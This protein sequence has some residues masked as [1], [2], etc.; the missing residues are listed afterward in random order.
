MLS[1]LKET[2]V[3]LSDLDRLTVNCQHCKTQVTVSL[4]T[5]SD[6]YKKHGVVL[7]NVCPGCQK[8]YDVTLVGALE[9]LQRAFDNLSPLAQYLEFRI[10]SERD[11]S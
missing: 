5:P 8:N 7:A 1:M 9:S 6:L 10:A 3:Y 11:V 4:K 2:I